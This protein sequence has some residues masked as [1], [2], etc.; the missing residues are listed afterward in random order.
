MSDEELELEY[1]RA[2]E[3][4]LRKNPGLELEAEIG[5][6]YRRSD[7]FRA[8]LRL[9]LVFDKLFFPS[10]P[11]EW[12]EET[13]EALEH[14]ELAARDLRD[15][16]RRSVR[17][18]FAG[19]DWRE[20]RREDPDALSGLRDSVR[21]H[22]VRKAS[23]ETSID[24][25][26]PGYALVAH[27]DEESCPDLVVK[28]A[29]LW[30]EVEDS[31]EAWEI[32]AARAWL[33]TEAAVRA[34]LV[35]DGARDLPDVRDRLVA[36][37][38]VRADRNG[39][40]LDELSASERFPSPEAWVEY[41]ALRESY[42]IAVVKDGLSADGPELAER[43]ERSSW[44]HGGGRVHVEILLA[45]AADIAHHRW[46][47]GGFERAKAKADELARR[48]AANDAAW[49]ARVPGRAS[50]AGVEP[51]VFWNRLLDEE[52][53]WWDPPDP[54]EGDNPRPPRHHGRFYGRTWSELRTLLSESDATDWSRGTA[55]AT[56]V[57]FEQ[58]P[59]TIAGPFRCALGFVLVR[60]GARQA[61]EARLDPTRPDD[62]ELLA[63]DELRE[64]FDA[65]A[66]AAREAYGV[67]VE[68]L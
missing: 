39:I 29:E 64:R 9:G 68:R 34:R 7:W 22:L 55:I 13:W 6:T 40:E 1:A 59:G 5:R 11:E 33:A 16:S 45:S 3:E 47:P 48:I 4:F 20:L 41:L 66:M 56:H 10:A 14:Q 54:R 57:A 28:T 24:G 65:Y 60:L 43:I 25:I 35:R 62:S 42:R 61:P 15:L 63:E 19:R 18:L 67:D 36:E 2:A 50:N 30:N 49:K 8:E 44:I 38:R 31:V 46:L 51:F 58:K 23:F 53:E 52:S 26:A 21:R 12:P 37:L 27:G 32:T 17:E